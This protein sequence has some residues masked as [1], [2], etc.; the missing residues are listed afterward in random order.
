M[1]TMDNGLVRTYR[2]I[3]AWAAKTRD[4]ESTVRALW[5]NIINLDEQIAIAEADATPGHLA[6]GGFISFD[7]EVAVMTRGRLY[8]QLIHTNQQLRELRE[9]PRR[10]TKLQ[11]YLE[12]CHSIDLAMP[13][14]DI[15]PPSSEVMEHEEIQHALFPQHLV[16]A[17][18]FAADQMRI[19]R[20]LA[21]SIDLR[22]KACYSSLID[23]EWMRSQ[24]DGNIVSCSGSLFRF[25]KMAVDEA[26]IAIMDQIAKERELVQ[27]LEIEGEF[28]S[29]S[30]FR[31]LGNV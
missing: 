9:A 15:L 3:D 16:P 12:A 7:H 8:D 17:K 1:A 31:T 13:S 21:W 26:V 2:D 30:Y 23:L 20:K 22:A 29:D 6:I 4:A 14:R 27:K 5:S 10:K 18:D 19:W 24:V 25:I 28:Y 11:E